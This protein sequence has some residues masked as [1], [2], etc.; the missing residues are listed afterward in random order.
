MRL[1][2]IAPGITMSARHLP[3][4][5]DSNASWQVDV[6]HF[7]AGRAVISRCTDIRRQGGPFWEI[8]TSFHGD[9]VRLHY[10]GVNEHPLNSMD[11]ALAYLV[12][13]GARWMNRNGEMA[14]QRTLAVMD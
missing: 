6:E 5:G 3:T 12:L 11:E 8:E 14:F 10:S 9:G 1:V 7:A 13:L 4:Q 2:E